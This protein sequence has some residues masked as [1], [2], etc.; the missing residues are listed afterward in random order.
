MRGSSR[1]NIGVPLLRRVLKVMVIVG[2]E[3]TYGDGFPDSASEVSAALYETPDSDRLA[4]RQG[5]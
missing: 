3:I 1:N 2:T 5:K 4:G